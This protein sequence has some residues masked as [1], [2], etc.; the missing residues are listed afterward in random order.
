MWFHF[1]ECEI[2]TFS[3]FIIFFHFG[4][5]DIGGRSRAVVQEYCTTVI[6]QNFCESDDGSSS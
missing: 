1:E 6:G 4:F 3:G 5:W 2:E